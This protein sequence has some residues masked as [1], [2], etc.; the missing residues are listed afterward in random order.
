VMR[1]ARSPAAARVAAAIAVLDRGYGRPGPMEELPPV[2]EKLVVTLK[3][4]DPDCGP[5]PKPIIDNS[6][7]AISEA[8]FA[9]RPQQP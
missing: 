2:K 4:G 5:C 9:S 1:N 7:D 6:L 8:P 3:L